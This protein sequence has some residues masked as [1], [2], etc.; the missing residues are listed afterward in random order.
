MSNTIKTDKI[1]NLTDVEFAL[2][3]FRSLCEVIIAYHIDYCCSYG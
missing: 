1:S 3:E 2:Q